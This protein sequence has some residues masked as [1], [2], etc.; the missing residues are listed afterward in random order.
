VEFFVGDFELCV[1]S[2][3]ADDLVYLDPPYQGTTYGRDKRYFEQLAVERLH[4]VLADLNGREVPFLLSY[5]GLHGEKAY[6]TV[7]PENLVVQRRLLNAGRSSQATLNG[8]AVITYESLY[9]SSH[10]H[11]SVTPLPVQQNPTQLLLGI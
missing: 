11:T 10:F 6:G 1:N 4:Q 7:L 8:K 5:D 2:A 3:T 9:L